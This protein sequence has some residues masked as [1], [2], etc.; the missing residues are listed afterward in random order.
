MRLRPEVFEGAARIVGSTRLG[1]FTY[2]ALHIRRNELQ[3]KSSWLAA[4]GTLAN[5]RALMDVG[6]TIYIATDE[7]KPDFFKAIEKEF[8]VVR[9]S[10]F[11][12][13]LDEKSARAYIEA[14]EAGHAS[15][16]AQ[17]HGAATHDDVDD[18]HLSILKFKWLPK[19]A[20]DIVMRGGGEKNGGR[21]ALAQALGTMEGAHIAAGAVDSNEKFAGIL[22]RRKHVGLVE[23]AVCMMA[24][25]FIGT[26]ALIIFF[27]FS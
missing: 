14:R 9:W 25:R 20:Q 6:E 19:Y 11:F 24:K 5:T 23:M 16:S 18:V 1:A 7:V 12:D 21:V 15:A 8:R 26:K 13:E 4:E 17:G 27:G 22:V 2:S 10:D 3:Y